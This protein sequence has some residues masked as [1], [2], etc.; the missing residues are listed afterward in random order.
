MKALE[1]SDRSQYLIS[2]YFKCPVIQSNMLENSVPKNSVDFITSLAVIDHYSNPLDALLDYYWAL[3]DKG[4]LFIYTPN[5]KGMVFNEGPSNYFK[6][7]HPYC[8]SVNS[9]CALLEKAGFGNFRYW[10]SMPNYGSRTLRF[11]NNI[12]VG[13]I[14]IIA[15][16][17]V[18]K[19]RTGW[20]ARIV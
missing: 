3:K 8:F 19:K 2:E 13:N 18:K 9:L 7:V 11:P 14:M 17:N 1:V 4:E 16:K 20:Q 5:V 6:F 10:T 15:Q 12:M